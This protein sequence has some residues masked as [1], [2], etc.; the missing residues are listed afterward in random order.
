[1]AA[2]PRCA[3]RQDRARFAFTK[4]VLYRPCARKTRENRARCFLLFDR[5]N[6]RLSGAFAGEEHAPGRPRLSFF[7]CAFPG[8]ELKKTI[9]AAFTRS[10]KIR[11]ARG[12]LGF[13]SPEP[14]Q[15]PHDLQFIRS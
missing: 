6:S 4:F 15:K 11:L 10:G 14:L 2:G 13:L 9:W 8:S 7:L 1:M 5:R 12:F 3:L